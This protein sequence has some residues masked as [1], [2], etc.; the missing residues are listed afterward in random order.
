MK[1]LIEL[2]PQD[3]D[4]FV[5]ECHK[6]SRDSAILKQG[7]VAHLESSG[8]DR[9]LIQIVCDEAEVGKLLTTAILLYPEVVGTMRAAIDRARNF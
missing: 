8:R 2:S 4:L 3:Y 5:A 9:R 1:V 7:V 6:I